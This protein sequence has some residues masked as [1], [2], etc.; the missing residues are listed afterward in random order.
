MQAQRMVRSA[1]ARP[2]VPRVEQK[3][4]QSQQEMRRESQAWS[5][6]FALVNSVEASRALC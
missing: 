6:E 5:F 3:Q 2:R 4:N 1:Q